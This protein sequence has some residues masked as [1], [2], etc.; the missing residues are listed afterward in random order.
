MKRS[1]EPRMGFSENVTFLA[2]HV[3]G[4]S[5][6]WEVRTSDLRKDTHPQ[7]LGMGINE[8][9]RMGPSKFRPG[10]TVHTMS[11]PLDSKVYRGG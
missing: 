4:N 10:E 9:W 7:T 5:T 3:Q 11:W 2:D 8:A 6:K 1:F